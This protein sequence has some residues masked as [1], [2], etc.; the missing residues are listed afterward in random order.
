VNA[1]AR[2]VHHLRLRAASAAQARRGALC[3]EDALRCAGLAD[4]GARLLM[5]R[6]LALGRVDPTGSSQTVALLIERR[7]Q[8]LV[9]PWRHGDAADAA[10]CDAVW[11]HDRG[12]ALV[13]LVQR[14]ARH[15]PVQAWYWR[16]VLPAD[17]ARGNRAPDLRA[18][19]L[20]LAAE[21]G[22]AVYLAAV[23]TTLLHEG[24]HEALRSALNAGEARAVLR[25]AG[26]APGGASAWVET[27]DRV[28]QS[29]SPPVP[30]GPVAKA[31]PQVVGAHDSI[32][33]SM[34]DSS[35]APRRPEAD[36]AANA[37]GD[38]T[39]G[40]R[41]AA[42]EPAPGRAVAAIHALPADAAP[43]AAARFTEPFDTTLPTAAG[44]CL[45]LLPL[46]ARLGFADWNAAADPAQRHALAARVL[47]QALLRLHVAAHDPAHAL[48]AQLLA[49]GAANDAELMWP[50]AH[51]WAHPHIGLVMPDAAASP[52]TVA[53]L[54]LTACRRTLRR[55]A[56]IGLASL[57][58]RPARLAWT[59]SHIDVHF[60]MS[61]A[62]GRVRRHGLDLDP[63]WLP[64]LGRVV[65]FHYGAP[66]M[67]VGAAG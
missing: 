42:A 13:C 62:D 10:A 58:L 28:A 17:A 53:A 64:W 50:Q 15:Q 40:P 30:P 57:A 32:H 46:L 35:A 16:R 9:L 23:I 2:T 36:G 12:E 29:G 59:R 8:Q 14:L 5:V 3:I 55:S 22:A 34:L 6:R 60:K 39:Q 24:H 49:G 51:A 41:R 54:W 45:F 33:D 67:R 43:Q 31:W 26:L 19:L 61:Q 44:G 7:M 56:R 66:D 37:I 18:A 27:F 20:A 11:F 48:A 52:D 4:A 1:A 63:G 65:A 25:V 21:P 47:Q 38:A